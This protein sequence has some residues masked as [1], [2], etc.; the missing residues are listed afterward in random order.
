MALGS[1]WYILFNVIAGASAIPTDLREMADQFR[2]PWRQRW[3]QLIL[4]GIF[5]F[6]VTGGITAA[7]GAWNASIV[8]EVVDY[9]HHHLVANGLGA[10]IT[11]ATHDRQLRRGPHRCHRDEFLCRGG[12]PAGVA[13]D[14]TAWPRPAIRCE[15]RAVTNVN[16]PRPQARVWMRSGPSSST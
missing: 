14:C 1:Q 16:R 10:Y 13:A 11:Q 8:A 7:G 15:D 12:E 5:P 6:Y 9:G 3:R 2:L 4:P